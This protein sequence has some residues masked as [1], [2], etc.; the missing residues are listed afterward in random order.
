MSLLFL[1]ASA[2][3]QAPVPAPSPGK[4]TPERECR[5]VPNST[6]SRLGPKRECRTPA[7]WAAIDKAGEQDADAMRRRTA[8]QTY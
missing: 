7:E 1:L 4:A 5:R 8:R 3:L 2:T 6:G